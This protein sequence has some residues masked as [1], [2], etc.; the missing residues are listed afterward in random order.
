MSAPESKPRVPTVDEW[1]RAQQDLCG[2]RDRQ[3]V[4]DRAVEAQQEAQVILD[5][6]TKRVSVPDPWGPNHVL[7]IDLM[8]VPVLHPDAIRVAVRDLRAASWWAYL[9]GG[10]EEESFRLEVLNP[11]QEL[12]PEQLARALACEHPREEPDDFVVE[13]IRDWIDMRT[14]SLLPEIEALLASLMIYR[15]NPLLL[16]KVLGFTEPYNGN[17]L[18]L[19][20]R[21]FS[22]TGEKLRNDYPDDVATRLLNKRPVPRTP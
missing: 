19:W 21:F 12:T 16:V 15:V 18:L 2:A 20:S 4:F 6:F 22:H 8:V 5:A 3:L 1:T 14:L 9:A 10:D 7:V 13:Q 11:K 17:P